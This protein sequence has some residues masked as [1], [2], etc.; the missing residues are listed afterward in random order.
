M[1]LNNKYAHNTLKYY[2]FFEAIKQLLA[3]IF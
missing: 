3:W 1:Q 2:E